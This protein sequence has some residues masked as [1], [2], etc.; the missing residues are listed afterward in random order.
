MPD[1]SMCANKSCPK[2]LD[3]YRFTATPSDYQYFA[4][5]EYKKGKCEHFW[6][7]SEYKKKK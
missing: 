1:I 6:D 2:K 3:C 5:F 7:N 4:G